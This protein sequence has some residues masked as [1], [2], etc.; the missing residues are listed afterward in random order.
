MTSKANEE[1]LQAIESSGGV[2]LEAGAGSGKTF[3]IIEHL[4]KKI[5]DYVNSSARS[6]SLSLIHI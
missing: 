3:V 2:I 6:T 1:Q 5:K 4:L